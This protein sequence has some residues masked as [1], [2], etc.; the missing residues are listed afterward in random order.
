MDLEGVQLLSQLPGILTA[1]VH[2]V[3]S[4]DATHTVR[5]A[6]WSP[7]LPAAA[8]PMVPRDSVEQRT[9]MASSGMLFHVA[10]VRAD[11]LEELSASIIRVTRIG[12]LG[13]LALTSN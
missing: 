12:E 7:L 5:T 6:L 4:E 9:T 13:M 10:L 8:P 1:N 11:I 3:D 2:G